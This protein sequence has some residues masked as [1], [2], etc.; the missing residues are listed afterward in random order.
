MPREMTITALPEHDYVVGP[1]GYSWN[2]RRSTGTGAFLSVSEGNRDREAAVAKGLSLAEADSTD[3]WETV[4]TGVFW[5][6]RRF[7]P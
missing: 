5:R 2:V 7:R 6:L 3:V 4:G 1:T